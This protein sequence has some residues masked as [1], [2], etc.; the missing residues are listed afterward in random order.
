[1]KTHRRASRKMAS[2][3]QFV[4][5]VGGCGRR[6]R[7]LPAILLAA[8]FVGCTSPREYFA[9]G[10]KVGPNYCRPAAAVADQWQDDGNAAIDGG[11][12]QNAAWWQTFH[13]PVLNS[14]IS[15]ACQQNLTLRVAGLRILEARA[16]R[17]IVAGN[18]FPQNQAAVGDYSRIQLSKNGPSGV[19]PDLH[20]NDVTLGGNLSWELDFWGQFRRALEAAD[21]NLDASVE[22]YDQVLVLLL[23]EVA[24]S[25]ADVRI[26]EQRLIYA[27]QNLDIQRGSLRIVEDRF[28]HGAVTKLDVTQGTANLEQTDSNIPPLEAQRRQAINQLCILMGMPP[29]NLDEMLARQQGIPR[30]PTHVAIGIP[31]ELLR[32]RP[33]V[34]K[35]ERDV[36]AQSAQIGVATAELYPHFSI[37]G[38]IYVDAMDAKKLFNA[39]SVAGSVGPSFRWNVLNYG[40]LANNINVQKAR[41]QQLVLQYQNTVLLANAESE[42][43]II[44]FIKSQQRVVSLAKSADASRES[45]ELVSA[46]YREGTVDFNWVFTVQQ[47]LTQQQDQLAVAEGS[48]VQYLIQLYKSLGGGWQ[49]RLENPNMEF[50]AGIGLPANAAP[51]PAVPQPQQAPV[52]IPPTQPQKAPVP[53]PPTQ[54]K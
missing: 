40:R 17:A 38:T 32:R 36:A 8:V 29:Q 39:D 6:S 30:T 50:T 2:M 16:Q 53:L 34:R 27:K 15:S 25:Y 13:D 35:A 46:Q 42:T 19:S 47:T 48:V 44:N 22:S 24:Q 51:A 54:P 21:A 11:P 33:D 10:F 4:A 12:M 7:L 43:A 52:P 23:A 26:A 28:R 49:A 1:M 45:V 9:N 18:L 37:D 14:L 41:F 3:S 31:A 20:F 5:H